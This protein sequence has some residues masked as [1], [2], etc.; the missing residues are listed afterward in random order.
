M[1]VPGGE[2]GQTSC[3]NKSQLLVKPLEKEKKKLRQRKIPY[4]SML[5]IL[6]PCH[7]HGTVPR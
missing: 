1:Q 5:K 7:V 2:T 3:D 4:P 6:Q